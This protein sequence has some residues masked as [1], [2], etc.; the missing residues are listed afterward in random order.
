[1]FS[2]KDGEQIFLA[3]VSD[4]QWDTFCDALGFADLKADPLLATNNDRVRQRATM[5][6]ALRQRLAGRTAA[7]LSA[8]F[9]RNGP[10][11]APIVR[12]EQL[13]DD[14]H[15]NATGGLA[16]ITLPDGERAPD[17]PHHAVPAA[18][19]R[20]TPGRAPAATPAGRAHAVFAGRP[21]LHARTGAG[22]ARRRG[23]G[24]ICGIL[25]YGAC[26]SGA[27]CY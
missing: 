10:P 12:P 27:G 20:P 17:G 25:G 21:G 18:H 6:P 2:V 3:A 11:Y 16:D 23:R 22:A 5:L 19:G 8:L 15:L 14:P 4:A 13:Y 1:M 24:L 9:E 7:E 26:Q